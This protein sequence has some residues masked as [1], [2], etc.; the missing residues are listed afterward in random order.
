MRFDNDSVF[1]RSV[2]DDEM[3]IVDRANVG[4]PP[5]QIVAFQT[6]AE[7]RQKSLSIY[8]TLARV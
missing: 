1:E 6:S 3:L 8:S 4:T 5:T 2:D 7:T